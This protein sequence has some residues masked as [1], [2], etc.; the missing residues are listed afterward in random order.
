[1]KR[2]AIFL[3][4]F[5]VLMFLVTACDSTTSSNDDLESVLK[6]IVAADS[7]IIINGIDDRG[8]PWRTACFFP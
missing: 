2:T 3:L 8:K 1:M 4:C 7:T 6:E 5:T